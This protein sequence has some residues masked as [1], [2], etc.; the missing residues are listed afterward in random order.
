[1]CNCRYFAD[2]ANLPTFLQT[3]Y[4]RAR[5]RVCIYLE[6]GWLVVR[7]V[8]GFCVAYLVDFHLFHA[9]LVH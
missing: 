1:M 4:T 7:L 8:F 6:K 5:V 2:L 3:L 9:A